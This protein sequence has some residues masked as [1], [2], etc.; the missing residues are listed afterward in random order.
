MERNKEFYVE[1]GKRLREYRKSM[2]YTQ[3]QTSELL[4]INENFYGKLERA[5]RYIPVDLIVTLHKKIGVD[6]NYLL[7]GEMN[8]QDSVL[9]LFK[10][11]PES[12][13]GQVIKVFTEV[14]KLIR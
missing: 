9:N 4:E 10:D 3:E 1:M 7:T 5:E 14:T 11:I 12:H 8:V 2:G 13:R 6:I